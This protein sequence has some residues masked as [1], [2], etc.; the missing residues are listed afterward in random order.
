MGK[1]ILK[2]GVAGLSKRG[3]ARVI[4][5]VAKEN[6]LGQEFWISQGFEHIAGALPLGMDLT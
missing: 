2:M 1:Q 3:I 6:L 5:L 4:V